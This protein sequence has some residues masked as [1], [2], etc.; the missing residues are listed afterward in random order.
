MSFCAPPTWHLSSH[1]GDLVARANE[2]TTATAAR[3]AIGRR[4]ET[5][6]DYTNMTLASLATVA[7]RHASA[8][9]SIAL[10]TGLDAERQPTHTSG[11]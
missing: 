2:A 9:A 4:V 8:T 6:M 3:G 10:V 5:L 7:L 1:T 11:G